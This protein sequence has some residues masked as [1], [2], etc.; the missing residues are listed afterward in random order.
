MM[1]PEDLQARLDQLRQAGL[2]DLSPTEAQLLAASIIAD[3]LDNL[4][5]EL[6]DVTAAVERAGATR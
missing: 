3:A 5:V 4:V 2:T 1:D 6:S